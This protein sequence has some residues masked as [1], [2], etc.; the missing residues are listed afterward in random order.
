MVPC[1]YTPKELIASCLYTSHSFVWY[2]FLSSCSMFPALCG[3]YPSEGID[4]SFL[5]PALLSDI[6]N[7]GVIPINL[8]RLFVIW[9]DPD[10]KKGGRKNCW[11]TLLH[12]DFSCMVVGKSFS[13]L[14]FC[15]ETVSLR[16]QI[17]LKLMIFLL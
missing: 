14:F 1:M 4:L 15:F 5:Q 9:N 13:L 6:I 17:G 16:G 8:C 11:P 7:H 10:I 12:L 2:C 3:H